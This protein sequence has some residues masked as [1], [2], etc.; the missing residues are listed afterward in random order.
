MVQTVI[1]G[2]EYEIWRCFLSHLEECLVYKTDAAEFSKVFI[3]FGKHALYSFILSQSKKN[4]I[5]NSPGG[6]AP[7]PP[8]FSVLQ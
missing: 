4:L 3:A 8:F 7:S 6:I 1:V 2:G 5:R